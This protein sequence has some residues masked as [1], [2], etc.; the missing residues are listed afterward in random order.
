M[1][2]VGFIIT[3]IL[4]VLGGCELPNY[5]AEYY[6]SAGNPINLIEGFVLPSNV[7][8]DLNRSATA[9]YPEKT[10]DIDGTPTVVPYPNSWDMFIKDPLPA[11]AYFTFNHDSIAALPGPPAGADVY[12]MEI[13]D[14]APAA[15]VFFN[16]GNWNAYGADPPTPDT[17]PL[18]PT[19]Y[20][21]TAGTMIDFYLSSAQ[22]LWFEIDG[23]LADGPLNDA[24]YSSALSVEYISFKPYSPG[25]NWTIHTASVLTTKEIYLSDFT[26]DPAPSSPFFPISIGAM[27]VVTQQY[28]NRG[29]IQGIRMARTDINY[30]IVMYLTKFDEGRP[31]LID[32]QYT[33]S[34]WVRNEAAATSD[35]ESFTLGISSYTSNRAHFKSFNASEFPGGWSSWTKISIKTPIDQSME[36]KDL[37]FSDYPAFK[38]TISPTYFN[39]ILGGESVLP[40]TL[41]FS[42]PELY[43][44]TE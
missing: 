32:G 2:R 20:E 28:A 8:S 21:I 19:H 43:F 36:I 25:T 30:D 3:L 17:A 24:T 44:V 11:Y 14:L 26:F 18:T 35:I 29:N 38:L 13:A 40:G 33:F 16:G 10:V 37:P 7:D 27:N 23:R 31:P 22:S 34:I 4:L 42:S 9:G 1:K 5:F 41:M 15:G 39:K 12:I 6:D